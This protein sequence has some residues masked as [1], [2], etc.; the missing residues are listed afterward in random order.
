MNVRLERGRSWAPW[1]IAVAAAGLLVWAIV[2]FV[3]VGVKSPVVRVD[4]APASA[5]GAA[6]ADGAV[7]PIP[8]HRLLPDAT[9][10]LGRTVR[11]EG[12]VAAVV[13]DE[14]FWVR[15][16]RDHVVFVTTGDRTPAPAAVVRV[17][18]RIEVLPDDERDRYLDAVRRAVPDTALL[19]RD[20]KL[21]STDLAIE[22][23][24]R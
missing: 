18:G 20:V 23:A 1:L 6:V 12:T 14:G 16:L 13:P 8:L 10:S 3:Y 9:N 24:H 17:I 19:V 15:D 7:E 2:D 5:P 11:V 4:A 21:V 22:V